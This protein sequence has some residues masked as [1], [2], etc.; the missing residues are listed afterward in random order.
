[1]SVPFLDLGA[2]HA[3]L[4]AELDAA[5]QRVLDSGRYVLG[6]ECTAFEREFAALCGV[7]ECVGVSNGLDA[8]RLVL[9]ARG[10]GPGDEVIVPS[11]TFIA[12]WLAVSQ[13]GATPVPVEVLPDTFN[14]DPARV[15]AAAGSRTRAI[16]AVH[17]YGQIADMDALRAVADAR[18]LALV[19]DAAQAHGARS[20]GRPA[21]GLGDAAAFSFYPGKN[22]GAL[23][24][25]GAVVTDDPELAQRVRE[26]RNYGSTEK[27]RHD[28]RGG[29][30]RLDELQAALLRVKL[31]VLE[32]WNER[33]RALA[34]RYLDELD[35]LA[36]PAVP[37]WADPVWHLFAVRHPQRDRLQ[38]RLADAG[39]ETLIHYPVP[40]HLC[41]AY[42]DL[43]LG[44]GSL[45][46][47]ERIADEQLSLPMGPHVT[48]EQAALVIA[49]VRAAA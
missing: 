36:L 38:S 5:W 41:G 9:Q 21:G 1:V 22:L 11:H 20:R 45:P 47:A 8:L 15:D 4:R 12:T 34:R 24:D 3:E 23:G 35:G 44:P 46:I 33:R 6:G 10:V 27:Y 48:D 39:V 19:E 17:L 49:A 26:L 29:N 43:G 2:A 14:L 13:A 32:T 28:A 42:A 31:A 40:P 25:G 30:A 37:D 7:R 18:G 16:V